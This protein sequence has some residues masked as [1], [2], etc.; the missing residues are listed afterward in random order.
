MNTE[1]TMCSRPS[2]GEQL[3]DRLAL[4]LRGGCKFS[5]KAE[6]AALGGF[7]GVVIL[8]NQ[9]TTNVNKISGLRSALTDDI[10]VIFLLKTEADLLTDLMAESDNRSIS[11]TGGQSNC[12]FT[13]RSLYNYGSRL[14]KL[15]PR[16]INNFHNIDYYD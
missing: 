4:V 10:P 7:R 11:I 2:E 14:L 3:P 13:W 5:L 1:S 15:L 12:A 8:D 16:S 6:N 9:N